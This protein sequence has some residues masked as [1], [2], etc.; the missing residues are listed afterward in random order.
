MFFIL[1]RRSDFF[2]KNGKEAFGCDKEEAHEEASQDAQACLV[3]LCD[4]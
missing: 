3:S 1:K 4:T 2:Q